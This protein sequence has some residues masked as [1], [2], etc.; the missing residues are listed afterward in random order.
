MLLQLSPSSRF[1]PSG[2]AGNYC[3]APCPHTEESLVV[4]QLFGEIAAGISDNAVRGPV[5]IDIAIKS[6]NSSDNQA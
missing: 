1:S 2:A 6:Q 3:L 4:H 5:P